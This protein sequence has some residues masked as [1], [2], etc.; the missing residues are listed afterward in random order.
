[1]TPNKRG[2]IGASSNASPMQPTIDTSNYDR[3][4]RVHTSRTSLSSQTQLGESATDIPG[5]TGSRRRSHV[6]NNNKPPARN[7]LVK[8]KTGKPETDPSRLRGAIFSTSSRIP[9]QRK[10]VCSTNT[11]RNHYDGR[12][13]RGGW[14]RSAVPAF[15]WSSAHTW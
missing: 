14:S 9:N 12:A 4:A 2:T 13:Q 1:M 6:A 5:T 3:H 10:L 8:P 11:W 7:A 15:A